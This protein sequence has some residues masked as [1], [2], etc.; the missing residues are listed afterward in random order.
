M[1]A[2]ESGKPAFPPNWRLAPD[3]DPNDHL[4]NL[5]GKEYLNVQHRLLWFMRDQRDMI[6]SGLATVPYIIRTELV[7]TRPRGGMGAL[8]HHRS[9]RAWQ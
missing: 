9:R 4:M 8:Q 6:A 5:K 3:Y 7:E 2:V 1:S